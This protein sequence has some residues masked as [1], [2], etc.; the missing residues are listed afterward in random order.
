M[1]VARTVAEL[2]AALPSR[3]AFVGFVPTMGAL[4]DGHLSL[5]RAARAAAD[6]VV[7]S[8]F[9]NP[10]QFGPAED[11][12]TYPRDEAGD[13]DLLAS[14]DVD[15]VFLP[16]VAEM[17]PPARSTT[18]SPG[19]IGE[20]LEGAAR[21]GHFDG[22]ATVVT[23]LLNLVRPRAAWFGQ[24]DAQQLA[25]IR[26]VIADLS[27]DVEIN[28][29]PTVR[30]PDGVAM[31]SR[32]AYLSADDRIRATAL[33]SA[34]RAGARVLE[35][36]RDVAATEKTML[37]TMTAEGVDADYAVVVDPDDFTPFEW[38]GDAALLAVAGRVGDTRLIDNLLLLPQS[39][40][41]AEG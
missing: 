7:V 22:V 9:V 37:E 1:I 16:S 41:R 32:N 30:E 28:A 14:E 23:K 25:V 20:I 38:G 2:R 12:D 33:Y 19:A 35:T 8:I 18:V 29:V 21:P 36:E 13:M 24:K 26:R 34:L 27:L 10:L 15:V 17:Y 5:V 11:L 4:H 3:D 6:V 39:P 40:P 31:S